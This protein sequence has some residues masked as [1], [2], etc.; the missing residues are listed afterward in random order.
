[1][2][3]KSEYDLYANHRVCALILK[4]KIGFRMLSLVKQK[5]LK[6]FPTLPAKFFAGMFIFYCLFGYIAVNPLAK[7]LVP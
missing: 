5:I 3:L 7:K 1:M 4:L 2:L 6:F